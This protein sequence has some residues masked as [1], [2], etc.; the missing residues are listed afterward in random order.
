MIKMKSLLVATLLLGLSQAAGD[1][2][3]G[4]PLIG[5]PEVDYDKYG[6]GIPDSCIDDEITNIYCSRSIETND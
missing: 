5:D 6:D 4:I 3:G 2:D 1:D